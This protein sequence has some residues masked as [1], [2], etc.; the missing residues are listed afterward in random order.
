MSVRLG[1][2]LATGFLLGLATDL[3]LLVRGARRLLL[4]FGYGSLNFF[5]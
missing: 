5:L 2:K 1:D 3:G 4:Q